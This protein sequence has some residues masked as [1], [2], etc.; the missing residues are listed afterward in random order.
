MHEASCACGSTV[1]HQMQNGTA[2]C[3]NCGI[4]M[5]NMPF[6]VHT[7]VSTVP[8]YQ[9]QI[10]T[11]RKRFRKYL[12]RASRNQSMSTVP[13]ET[14][15]Y[16]IRRGPYAGLKGILRALKRSKLRRKCY[17][18]LPLMCE[19]LCENSVPF[20]DESEKSEAMLL[21]DV[22]DKALQPPKQFVSYVY[23]LEYILRRLGRPD[24]IPFINTIQCRK[25]RQKHNSLLDSIFRQFDTPAS[26]ESC[27]YHSYSKSH[28]FFLCTA[29]GRG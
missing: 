6:M 13:E 4:L 15:R 29:A 19:H 23:A 24:M 25:R 12:Q 17:D 11:R 21:F 14:W 5:G 20:L 16:L 10:Y 22:I 9:N 8:L 7:Y 1:L 2:V 28:D 26:E 27:Q 18:S 3:T